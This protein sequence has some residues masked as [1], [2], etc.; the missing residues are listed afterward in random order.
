MFR[1][2]VVI[3]I[4][5]SLGVPGCKKK[6][7]EPAAPANAEPAAPGAAAAMAAGA[8]AAGPDACAILTKD[9]I[10]EAVGLEVT[11]SEHGPSGAPNVCE[12][13]L[14]GDSARVL[15][16]I[17]ISSAKE[18]FDNAPG[19]PLA[20][21]GDQAKWI[22]SAGLLSVLRGETS[23][24]VAVMRFDDTPAEQKLEQ[25]KRLAARLLDRL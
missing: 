1:G 7:E 4:L 2:L 6:S 5:A 21:V 15:I 10:K 14:G 23:F 3:V 25:V 20:G 24:T 16:S 19:E 11:A 18:T 9:E 22:E 12:H 8:S 17:Y 13:K